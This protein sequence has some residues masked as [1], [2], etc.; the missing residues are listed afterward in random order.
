M[1]AQERTLLAVIGD[2]DS[3]TGMLLAGIGHVSDDD[4]RSKN[5]TVVDSKTEL[6]KIEA[7]FDSYTER[8]DI[9]ILLINQHVRMTYDEVAQLNS[10]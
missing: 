7:A 1:S 10:P 9:A 3:V 5:F 8:K 2:E 6:D 4:S